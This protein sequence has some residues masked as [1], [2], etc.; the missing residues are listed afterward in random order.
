MSVIYH[1]ATPTRIFNETIVLEGPK[2]A[3]YL[4]HVAGTGDRLYKRFN[5][6]TVQTRR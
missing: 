6:L 3:A 4:R 1:V 5:A 2:Y